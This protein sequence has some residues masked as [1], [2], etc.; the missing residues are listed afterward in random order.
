VQ[1]GANINAKVE[2]K[3]ERQPKGKARGPEALPSVA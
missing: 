2:T 3:V 1:E